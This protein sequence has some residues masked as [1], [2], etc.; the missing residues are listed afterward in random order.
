MIT[1]IIVGAGHRSLGYAELSKADPD[2]LNKWFTAEREK[3]Y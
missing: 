2:R 1:A 3:R